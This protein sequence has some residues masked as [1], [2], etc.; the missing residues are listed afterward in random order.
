VSGLKADVGASSDVMEGTGKGIMQN[1]ENCLQSQACFV[2]SK[3]EHLRYVG[4][5][6]GTSSSAMKRL[7]Q[8]IV[9]VGDG[10]ST[11]VPGSNF[12]QPQLDKPSDILLDDALHTHHHRVCTLSKFML[13]DLQCCVINDIVVM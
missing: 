5:A 13:S 6:A 2:C 7:H 1:G 12:S 10:T 8:I 9:M 3:K 4:V 11:E